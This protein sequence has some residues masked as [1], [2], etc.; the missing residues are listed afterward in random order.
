MKPFSYV[1]A[2]TAESAVTLVR[3]NGRFLAGGNDLL[4]EIKEGLVEP[5]TLVNVKSLAGT[6]EITPGRDR[7]SIGANVKLTTLLEHA[8]LRRVFPAVPMAA[9]DV[10]SPQMR[11]IAT[12]GGNLAQHSRCWY[13]RHRDVACLKKGGTRC[14]ARGGENK[15]HALFTG[16]RCVSP[17]VSNLAIA[18]S[19]LNASVVVQRGRQR[20]TLTMAKLYDRAWSAVRAH[21]SLAETDLILSVEIPVIAN[22]R[23]VYLQL[24][25][26]SDF[27]WALVS[28]AAS[29]VVDGKKLRNTRIVLG[30]VSPTPWRVPEA[31][32]LLDGREPTDDV[33]A[34]VTTRLLRDATPLEQNGYKVPLAQALVKRAL[35][36]IVA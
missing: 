23:S 9:A 18:L 20:E 27:D 16:G 19:A 25:E 15:Y 3:E 12:L 4:G 21:N 7:W 36:Q 13:Y 29:A 30:A 1:T 10:G 22:A 8:E 5:A 17:C 14:F 33:V 2:H 6:T 28:C 26:K 32:T 35:Q 24:A 11:N 31:D 34:R